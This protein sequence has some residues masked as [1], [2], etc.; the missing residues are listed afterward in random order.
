M[1]PT[2]VAT[3]GSSLEAASW[4]ARQKCSYGLGTKALAVND[5][6]SHGP[7]RAG[8]VPLERLLC[9]GGADVE[10]P[11]AA[12]VAPALESELERT[13]CPPADTR[14]GRPRARRGVIARLEQRH[15]GEVNPARD[16]RRRTPGVDQVRMSA[17]Q[18]RR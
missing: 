14:P 11:G 1:P 10:Q 16:H 18:L 4:A 6:R 17:A 7:L 8:H 3:S 15:R 5:P 2:R 13:R 12:A 9:L